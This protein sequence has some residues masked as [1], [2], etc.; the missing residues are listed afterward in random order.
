M[1][2]DFLSV[3]LKL[4]TLL[5]SKGFRVIMTRSTDVEIGLYE[6]D[7]LANAAGADL[8]ISIHSNAAEN[9]PDYQGIYTYYHPTSSQGARLAQAVQTPL[10]QV[11]GA[12][13]R[14]IRDADFV[15]L[16]ETDMPAVLVEMGFMTSHEEL[17]R[18]MDG[19]YQQQLAQGI[20]QG[21][22]DYLAAQALWAA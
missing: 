21:I 17:M 10:C 1:A 13:D 20:T 12:I 9:R 8:F 16:R 19:G 4:A 18:L 11:T 22:L 3:S 14:G 5:R 15:V 6:R 7:D 2:S